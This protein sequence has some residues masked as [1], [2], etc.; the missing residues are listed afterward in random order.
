MRN[1][2]KTS[3]WGACR[4]L[5]VVYLNNLLILSFVIDWSSPFSFHLSTFVSVMKSSYVESVF[6]KTLEPRLMALNC[7]SR[8]L[9]VYLGWV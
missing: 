4:R 3:F 2:S 9:Y 5:L 6:L 7:V 8:H 1:L